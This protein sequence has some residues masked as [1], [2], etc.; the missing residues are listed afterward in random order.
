LN[1]K[2]TRQSLLARLYGVFRVVV[3]ILIVVYLGWQVY[4][5]HVALASQNIAWDWGN[6]S[7]A[8]LAALLAYQC[9][10]AGWIVLLR[11]T[12]YY[13]RHQLRRYLRI[14]WVSYLY[15]YVPGKV[16][17]AVERARMGTAVG[18]PPVA[19]ASLTVVETMLAILAGSTVSL[20]ALSYYATADIRIFGGVAILAAGSIFLF[21]AGFRFLCNIPIVKRRF[22]ELESVALGSRDILVSVVPYV[23]HY[24][25]FGLSFFL[26][27][28]TIHE[29]PWS[30]FP[31][32]CGIYALS[33][34]VSLV[35]LVAPG[36]LGVREGA[37]AVQ[38]GQ[39]L[40]AGAAEALAIGSRLWFTLVEL[41]CYASVLLFCPSRP[42]RFR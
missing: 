30:A 21:P 18:I 32:L 5:G 14:W 37:L 27:S 10:F 15:R 29:F 41:V 7:G 28:R 40:P 24:L 19:G 20:L 31:G 38:L 16:L 34:V 2:S 42:E 9:L 22:P 33:H 26:L 12:G 11:R 36:G 23:L 3:L 13:S 25:L 4:V 39:L 35:A 8:F 6:L 1:D 17:L